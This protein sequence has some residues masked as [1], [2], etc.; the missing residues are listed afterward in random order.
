MYILSL[1]TISIGNEANVYCIICPPKGDLDA[2]IQKKE[3]IK[4]ISSDKGE[5]Y[6]SP[7]GTP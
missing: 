7:L 3:Q 4:Y 6:P 1:F 5:A 2:L